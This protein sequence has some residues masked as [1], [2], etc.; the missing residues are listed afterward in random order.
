MHSCYLHSFV[1]AFLLRRY[2]RNQASQS[3]RMISTLF[4]MMDAKLLLLL[5]ATVQNVNLACY[6]RKR[7]QMGSSTQRVS[8]V[9]YRMVRTQFQIFTIC[10][11]RNHSK[12]FIKHSF[13]LRAA[14][15][16][17]GE[18]FPWPLP[19]GQDFP[20]KTRGSRHF[21]RR[22]RWVNS[23]LHKNK[24]KKRNQLFEI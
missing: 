13:Q 12:Q 20:A 9:K 17:T 19:Q 8:R 7:K 3:Y 10:F 24:E 11:K 6:E 18:N 5:H 23:W 21:G 2:S 1:C 14:H 22:R 15:P 16:T 4:R